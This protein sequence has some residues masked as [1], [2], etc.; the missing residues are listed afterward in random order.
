M[1][2]FKRAP[3]EINTSL[4]SYNKTV[5]FFNQM[6][7]KGLIEN[8]NTFTVDQYSQADAKNVYVDDHGSLVSR[9]PLQEEVLPTTIIPE[10][11]EDEQWKLINVKTYGKATIYV[12]KGATYHGLIPQY[13]VVLK[14]DDSLYT[15]ELNTSNEPLLSTFENY[16][17]CFNDDT[18]KGAKVFDVNH[19]TSSWQDFA[20]FIEVPVIQRTVGNEVTIYP[21]NG[22]TSSYKY[23]YIWSNNSQPDLPNSAE[24]NIQSVG[25]KTWH[26]K[27]YST[28]SNY[29]LNAYLSYMQ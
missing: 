23:E 10:D 7:W 1:R 18:S 9:K 12:V 15:L 14:Y 2:T 20:K 29:N 27:Q 21:G 22:F 19:P 16:I 25:G 4:T 17:I 28:S 3:N 11:S 8:K 6:E 26:V 13:R 5:K 24:L